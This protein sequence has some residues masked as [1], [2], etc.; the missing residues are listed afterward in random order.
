MYFCVWLA[1]HKRVELLCM[2]LCVLVWVMAFAF[3]FLVFVFFGAGLSGV[4]GVLFGFFSIL[5][6]LLGGV[7]K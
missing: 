1:K 5:R 2:L 6:F 3:F 7:D 4:D